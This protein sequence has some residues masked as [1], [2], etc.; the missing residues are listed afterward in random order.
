MKNRGDDEQ[1]R[2]LRAELSRPGSVYYYYYCWCCFRQRAS[3]SRQ[4]LFLEC[5]VGKNRNNN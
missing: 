5:G 2:P 1:G 4:G 3:S